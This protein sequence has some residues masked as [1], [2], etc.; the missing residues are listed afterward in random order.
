MSNTVDVKVVILGQEYCGKTSLIQRYVNNKTVLP[1][2]VPSK[3]SGAAGKS[4][5]VESQKYQN[6]IGAAYR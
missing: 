2:A 1:T 5:D 4:V 3:K 6:T